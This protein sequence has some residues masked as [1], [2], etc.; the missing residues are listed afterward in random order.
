MGAVEAGF[1]GSLFQALD[2]I[3]LK[4]VSVSVEQK[5]VITKGTLSF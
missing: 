1:E 5:E 2:G 4:N 3:N